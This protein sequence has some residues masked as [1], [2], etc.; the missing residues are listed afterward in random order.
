MLRRRPPKLGEDAVEHVMRLGNDDIV[1]KPNHM[2]AE[3]PKDVR[4]LLVPLELILV[5]GAI[6]FDNQSDV[7]AGEVGDV[8]VDGNLTTE[9]QAGEF[10]AS[11]ELPEFALGEG[12]EAA[13]FARLV[14]AIHDCTLSP[15]ND[16]TI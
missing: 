6:E 16:N 13:E 15:R 10:A 14:D 4:P 7:E 11:Q 5:D 2:P 8:A 9:L 3:R 12:L 1:V